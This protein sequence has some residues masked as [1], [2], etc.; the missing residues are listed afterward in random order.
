V[1]AVAEDLADVTGDVR[2]IVVGR[3]H[4]RLLDLELQL[5]LSGA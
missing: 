2:E 1:P 3:R 5:G 4:G